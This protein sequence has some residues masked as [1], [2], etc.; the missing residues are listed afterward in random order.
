MDSETVKELNA[1]KTLLFDLRGRV[2]KLEEIQ[3][4]RWNRK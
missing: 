4:R 1:I 3:T 2:Q